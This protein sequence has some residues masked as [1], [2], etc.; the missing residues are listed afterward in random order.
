M[1][2]VVTIGSNTLD[3]FVKTGAEVRKVFHKQRI[4]GRIVESEDESL[5]YPVG[6]KILVDQLEFQIGGGGTNTADSFKTM[7]LKTGYIGKIGGDYNGVQ[8]YK[9]LEDNNIEFLGSIGSQ[10]G[11]SVILDSVSDDRTI[12]AYKGCNDELGYNEIKKEALNTK[13]LYCSSM[14]GDSYK[15]LK[16]LVRKAKEKQV[17]VAFNPSIYQAREGISKLKSVL[18]CLDLLVFNKEECLAMTREE[19]VQNAILKLKKI[20]PGIII[21]T[22]GGRGAFLYDGRKA[23]IGSPKKNVKIKETTGAGDAFA[24]AV[25]TGLV[26]GEKVEEALKM[27][28][29]QSESVIQSYGAKKGLLSKKKMESK[30]KKDNRIIK[31]VSLKEVEL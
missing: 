25:T 10:N 19:K 29:I 4:D 6:D 9:Y 13:W 28:F 8:V 24:S 18:N 15:T 1:Y 16:M 12:L 23:F 26:N 22:D 5:V 20:V 31:K 27:G 14:M 7:G 17:K 11:F 2:D 30:L 3:S 21:V